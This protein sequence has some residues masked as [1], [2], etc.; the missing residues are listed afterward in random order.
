[1]ATAWPLTLLPTIVLPAGLQAARVARAHITRLGDNWPTDAL[2]MARLLTSELVTNAVLHGEGDVELT[3]R[4]TERAVRVEVTDR[5]PDMYPMPGGPDS[6]P[7]L[8]GG[9]GLKIVAGIA[10]D[11]GTSRTDEGKT[12]W[13]NLRHAPEIASRSPFG[14][15]R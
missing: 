12:V 10:D 3:V 7:T 8:D 4:G 6:R 15:V 9:H 5:N 11:W 2:D 13:F 1:M 14:V